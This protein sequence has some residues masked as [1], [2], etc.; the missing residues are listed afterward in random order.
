VREAQELLFLLGFSVVIKANN[1]DINK[2]STSSGCS[3]SDKKGGRHDWGAST[4]PSGSGGFIPSVDPFSDDL[5][6][7]KLLACNLWAVLPL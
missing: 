4:K 1:G 3:L 6:S 2:S 5:R 7:N